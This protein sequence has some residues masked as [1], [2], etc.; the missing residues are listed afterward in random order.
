MA[1]DLLKGGIAQNEY[2]KP[3]QTRTS[4]LP[5]TVKNS[6]NNMVKSAL[7]LE[8]LRNINMK[9][10]KGDT[11]IPN[12]IRTDLTDDLHEKFGFRTDYEVISLKNFKKIFK[13]TKK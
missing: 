12:Y 4:N 7:F 10:E 11:Y 8:T 3:T 2:L 5:E 6:I 1:E 9:L 13:Q